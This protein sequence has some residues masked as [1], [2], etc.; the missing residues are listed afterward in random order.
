MKFC[1]FETKFL[2]LGLPPDYQECLAPLHLS[3]KIPVRTKKRRKLFSFSLRCVV[4]ITKAAG[5]KNLPRCHIQFQYAFLTV[6]RVLNRSHF[7]DS[8]LECIKEFKNNL[9]FFRL[10]IFYRIAS[11][12]ASC[13]IL[14]N[15]Y[16]DSPAQLIN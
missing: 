15:D 12:T 4:V 13:Y 5:K 7:K 8:V 2:C 9:V 11:W 16:V 1:I 6:C 10:I 14:S 3:N